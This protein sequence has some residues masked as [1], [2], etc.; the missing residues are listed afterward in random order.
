MKHVWASG[1]KGKLYWDKQVSICEE[2]SQISVKT[3]FK[4]LFPVSWCK[5]KN[6]WKKSF[7]GTYLKKKMKLAYA[8]SSALKLQSLN[9]TLVSS[10]LIGTVLAPFLSSVNSIFDEKLR[11]TSWAETYHSKLSSNG[12]KCYNTRKKEPWQP[13]S[14]IEEIWLTISER[15]EINDLQKKKSICFV[16][17]WFLSF[18]SYGGEATNLIAH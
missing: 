15:T 11:F 14:C 16:I 12:S 5:H 9:G 8:C 6:L 1:W 2:A 7:D 4:N 17:G 10:D 3:Y 18:R 13:R